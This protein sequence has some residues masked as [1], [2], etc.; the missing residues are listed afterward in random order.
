M[1]LASRPRMEALDRHL[2]TAVA[3]ATLETE[4]GPHMVVAD[5]L[6][7]DVYADLL[8]TMPPPEAF[9]VA[10]KSKANF[11]PSTTADVPERSRESW[12]WFHGDV[13]EKLLTPILM[14]AFRPCLTAAYQAQFGVPLAAD[15]LGLPHH[16]FQGRLMLRRP[17]YRLKPHRDKKIA[18]IT[19]LVYF[20]RPGDSRDYGTD[21]YRIVD[22]QQAPI[23]KT[24]YPEAHGGR[25]ELARTV[26]FVG[27]T[28][29]IF[30]NVPG[31]AHGAGIPPDAPQSER[32]AYQFYV[33]PPKPELARLVHRLPPSWRARGNSR[34]RMTSTDSRDRQQHA[35]AGDRRRSS[36]AGRDQRATA[37]RR[38]VHRP[39]GRG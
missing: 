15:A 28:G 36:R 4:P 21:L 39:V 24:Y 1:D 31:M 14:D 26:P 16:A 9:E 25:A 19:G 23:M 8:E 11:L 27:N 29:L 3:G 32:Y 6:P 37:V 34:A 30:M 18:A 17:G 20:A 10:D 7:D 5:L 33:G 38:V 2:R 35:L 22:D 13:V 12:S